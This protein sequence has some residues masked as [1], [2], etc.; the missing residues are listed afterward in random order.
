MPIT[1]DEIA[2]VDN[3]ARFYTADLHVHSYGA[4]SDVRDS[5]F[6]PEAII[7]SA[8]KQRISILAITD[9]NTDRNV[10]SCI[11]YA[12]KY[13]GQLL[14]LAGVEI[15]TANGHVLAYFAPQRIQ[16]VRTLLGQL[17]IVGDW[18]ARDS[19]TT[20]SMA[21]V[22]ARI[23]ASGGIA[24]AAHIDREKTGFEALAGGYPN[25][26]KDILLSSG[27]YGIEV[28]DAS[29]LGWFS[30][31]DESTP[32]GGE[33]TSVLQGRSRFT[34]T[35]GRVHLAHIQNSDA[36]SLAEFLA[37]RQ[38][39][40]LTR[41]KL[42]E[43][44]FEALRTA[45]VDPEA[46]VRA[47]VTVPPRVPRV[48]GMQI[49]GGFLDAQTYHLSDN[50]NCFIGGRGTGKSTAI[51]ALAYGLGSSDSIEEYENCPDNVVVYAEDNAGVR[52]RYERNRGDQPMVQA[53]E[54]R[55][56]TDVPADSFRIEYYGQGELAKV[57]EVE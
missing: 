42:N 48:L 3:G 10:Q 18:G 4:S 29:H 16:A 51:K 36:H 13:V 41:F 52:Y 53:K 57:A 26:K 14:V 32:T 27:L 35:A 54:D 1:F 12:Q 39:H 28:D 34:A 56:I 44:S 55:E 19:H 24:V 31:A 33:R 15:S 7:N 21:D 25:W 49:S 17:S 47:I 46:R 2:R 38:N 20:M 9:H 43:L 45:F 11:D 40:D 8:V 5:A 30:A 37:H 50:L 22:I 23:E 6:S